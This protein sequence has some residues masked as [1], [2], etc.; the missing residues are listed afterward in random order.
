M[1]E[2]EPPKKNLMVSRSFGKLISDFDTIAEALT[3][4]ATMAAAKLRKQKSKCQLLYIFL[5]TSPF[6]DY[7]P[8]ISKGIKVR[9]PVPTSSTIE[10]AKYGKK[11][12]KAIYEEGYDF[13]ITGIGLSDIVPEKDVQ[14][15]IYDPLGAEK[16]H[17]H[18]LLM[19]TIDDINEK[20]G[21]NTSKIAACGDSKKWWI[22][23]EKLCPCYTTRL[24]DII[25]A[26]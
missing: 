20:Y 19:V 7:L 9:L 17:K 22:K 16:R 3:N 13:K 14:L 23:Q 15:G 5:E 18:D 4:Y 25:I 24:T 12:L 2:I 1:E 26:V 11:G 8:Q 6:R 10:I 21:R